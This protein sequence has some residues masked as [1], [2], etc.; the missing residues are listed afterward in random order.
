MTKFQITM[1]VQTNS[2]SE[3]A[4]FCFGTLTGLLFGLFIMTFFP[5]YSLQ[6]RISWPVDAAAAVSSVQS[7]SSTNAPR[8]APNS[9][10]SGLHSAPAPT[11][12]RQAMSPTLAALAMSRAAAAAAAAGEAAVASARRTPPA[13]PP[14]PRPSISSSSSSSSPSSTEPFPDRWAKTFRLPPYNVYLTPSGDKARK[15][16]CRC[17]CP[18]DCSC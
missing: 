17:S 9:T 14:T 11:R 16:T 13:P 1:W 18:C 10:P 5:G 2:L 6:L 8:A 12:P 15:C 7:T 3:F 4:D